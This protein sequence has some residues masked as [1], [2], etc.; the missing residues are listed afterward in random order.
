MSW[1]WKDIDEEQ[2]KKVYDLQG[3]VTITTDEYRDMFTEITRLKFAGQREH[4]DFKDQYYKRQELEKKC[5]E[6]TKRLDELNAW[7]DEDDAARTKFKLWKV[8]RL[9]KEGREEN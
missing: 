5:T 3:T 7:L 8:E 4:D 2:E 1:N 6:L 9:E